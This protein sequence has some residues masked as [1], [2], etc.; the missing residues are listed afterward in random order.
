MIMADSPGWI[1]VHGHYYA[2]MTQEQA[3]QQF[4]ARNAGCF[5]TPGPAALEYDQEGVLAYL[6][7][8]RHFNANA[9]HHT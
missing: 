1:D 6:D 3:E 2:P 5:L 9:Q 4:K 7:W 8:G